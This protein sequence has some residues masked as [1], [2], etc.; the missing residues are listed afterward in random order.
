MSQSSPAAT[1]LS[2]TGPP[3][4][5]DLRR[6]GRTLA[7]VLLPIGPAAVAVLRFVLPYDTT[8]SGT[9][10]VHAIAAHQHRAD[11]TVWLGLV[12]VLTLVPAVL[13]VGR[14]TA[15]TAPRLTAAAL[16][17]LVPAYLSLAYLTGSDAIA[18]YGVQHGL[19]PATVADMY[20]GVHPVVLV[21]GLVFVLGHV[22]G[23][24]LLGAAMIRSGRVPLWAGVATLVS[25][26]VHFVAAIVLGSHLLDLGGWGLNA[27]GFAAVAVVVLAMDDDDWAPAPIRRAG[28]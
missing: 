11:L 3:P 20:T 28:A 1:V 18:L 5:A 13:W 25:Q 7:A 16:L 10:I 12:A 2:R 17:L 14:V 19:P 24:I 27:L 6:A 9:G 8:D 23:T 26:P 15:R 21:S 22:L 4:P